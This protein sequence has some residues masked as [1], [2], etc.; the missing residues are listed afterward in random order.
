LSFRHLIFALFLAIPPGARLGMH[1]LREEKQDDLT[2]LE[3]LKIDLEVTREELRRESVERTMSGLD[4]L[5]GQ[6]KLIAGKVFPLSDP[7][8]Q[9][10]VLWA[11]LGEGQPVPEDTAAVWQKGLVGR[12]SRAYPRLA[13]GRVQTLLDPGFRVRFRQGE[14]TGMLWG[15]G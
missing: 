12:V 6:Y 4:R 7:S 14:S 1:L 3:K 2:A 13:V 9:R 15:T 5:D 11:H 8:P 10:S